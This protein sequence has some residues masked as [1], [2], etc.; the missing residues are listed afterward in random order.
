MQDKTYVVGQVRDERSVGMETLHKLV[1]GV[2][3]LDKGDSEEVGAINIA[4]MGSSK[5]EIINVAGETDKVECATPEVSDKKKETE[6][7]KV[8][9]VIG[10]MESALWRREMIVQSESTM[11]KDGDV[12]MVTVEVA[13][14]EKEVNNGRGSGPEK[15]AYEGMWWR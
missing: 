13:S 3:M 15:R 6:M 10:W 2:E 7:K 5:D 1:A 14:H 4:E 8:D 11:A 12:D 9:R